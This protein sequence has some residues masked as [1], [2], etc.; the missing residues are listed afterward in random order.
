MFLVLI[1][2]VMASDKGFISRFS[3]SS[4][5]SCSMAGCGILC[6]TLCLWAVASLL[7]PGDS[8]PMAYVPLFN[9]LAFAEVSIF[10]TMAWWHLRTARLYPEFEAWITGRVAVAVCVVLTMA[11]ST[12]EAARIFHFYY[13]V[14]FT[15]PALWNDL[16]FQTAITL[17]WGLWSL[18]MMRFGSK[19]IEHRRIWSIGAVLLSCNVFKLIFADL[20]GSETL[21]RVF[22][23]LGLGV[24]LMLIGFLTPLPTKKE[25]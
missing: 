17:L 6:V 14:R 9:P 7:L 2:N 13:G 21:T 10:L 18:G 20:S 12:V 22:S 19:K 23:F 15:I 16:V 24:L 5:R 1:V 3:P 11:W 25:A 8:S 4:R